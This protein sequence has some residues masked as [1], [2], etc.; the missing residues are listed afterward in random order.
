[1]SKNNDKNNKKTLKFLI[2]Q[3][4]LFLLLIFIIVSVSLNAKFI[5]ELDNFVFNITD[6][7]RID[8]INN[9]LLIITTF[10][11]SFVFVILVIFFLIYNFKKIGLPL[12][13]L[14]MLSAII[15]FCLKNLVQRTRPV[16]QFV[17]NLIFNYQFPTSFSFPSGHSQTSLVFYFMLSYFLLQNYKGKHKKLFLTLTCIFVSLIALSRIVLGVHYFSD[18]VAGILIGLIIISN[19]IFFCSNKK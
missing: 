4:I 2:L 8:F 12:G 5:I 6:F 18:V 14:T 19:Y 1:M 3:V 10:G 17:N 11:E 13:F 15:N 16:G 9:F 7:I